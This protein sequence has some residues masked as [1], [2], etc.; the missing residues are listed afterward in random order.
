LGIAKLLVDKGADVNAGG[1]RC[2]TALMGAAQQGNLE[3]AKRL[4]SAGADINAKTTTEEDSHGRT[5]KDPV[6]K[7]LSEIASQTKPTETFIY[8]LGSC[9]YRF[10]FG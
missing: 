10:T 9:F 1:Y 7:F 3:V 6:E 5:Q 8:K 4:I 2:Y